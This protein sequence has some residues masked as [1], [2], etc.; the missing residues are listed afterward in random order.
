[1]LIKSWKGGALA[2]QLHP[3]WKKPYPVILAIF[4]AVKLQGIDSW[5]HLSS[6]KHAT[7]ESTFDQTQPGDT[8]SCEPIQDLKFIFWRNQNTS[9]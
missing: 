6:V 9:T 7:E 4:M 5:I 8:Y 2:D 1:V 3:T